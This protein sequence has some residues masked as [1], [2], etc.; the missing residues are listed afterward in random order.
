MKHPVG[1]TANNIPVYVDLTNSQAAVHIARHPHL[2][3]L[4]KEV[5]QRLAPTVPI[6]NSEHDMGRDIGYSFVVE[7]TDKDT[8]LYA[9]LL[10]DDIYTRFVKNGKPTKTSFLTILLLKE[11]DNTY[12][13]HDTW[14]GRINPPR[15][16]SPHE[17]PESES[18]WTNHAFILDNQTIQSRTVTRERPH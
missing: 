5:I 9:R 2:L 16:G 17:T 3:G 7:T 18:Y 13:L 11:D 14:I 8:I 1:L 6:V 15:P 10:H 12:A 4:V